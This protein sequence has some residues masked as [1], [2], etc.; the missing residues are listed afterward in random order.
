[1]LS[2]VWV[3][4]VG[5][6]L[7]QGTE[8]PLAMECDQ[9][10]KKKKKSKQ[11]GSNIAGW[12]FFFSTYSVCMYACVDTQSLSHIRLLVTQWTVAC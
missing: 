12:I 3:Q 8:V 2:N 7:G 1:M 10:L 4:G 11:C 6:I 5:S 9:N